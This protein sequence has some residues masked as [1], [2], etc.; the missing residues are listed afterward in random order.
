MHN[1]RHFRNSFSRT[2]LRA[3][4]TMLT[5]ATMVGWMVVWT[6]AA[7]AQTQ[8]NYKMI[9]PFTGGQDGANSYA[10]LTMDKTGKLYGTASAGGSQNCGG[11]CGLVFELTNN[12]SGWILNPMY[13]FQGGSD[14]STPDAR[15]V[16]GS[17]GSLYGTTTGYASGSGATVFKLSPPPTACKTA[18]CAWTQ[19]VLYD[20]NE[21]V[22]SL[23]GD[24]AFD[25]AGNIYGTTANTVYELT[26]LNGGW[27]EKILYNFTNGSDGGYPW[28]GVILDKTGSLYGT[29]FAG[30][31]YGYGTVFRLTLSES[32]WT[33]TVLYSFQNGS[34]GAEPAGGLIFDKSGNLY[35]TTSAWGLGKGGTVFKLTASN[36]NWLFSVI[37]SF[38]GAGPGP[39]GSLVM[40]EAGNLYGT[41][42]G[43]GA[44]GGGSVFKLTN[45]GD[46][47]QYT[48]LHSFNG[49]GGIN[50]F[51]NGTI[52][53]EGNFY[54]T[55]A[56]A[57]PYRTNGVVWEITP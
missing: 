18:Y 9:H 43:G 54:G 35:G 51:G 23:L 27:T 53:S 19:S 42:F 4:T 21:Y 1:Q 20:F 55:A 13:S 41:T 5:M 28:A 44:T 15:V 34:D 39:I 16:F 6:Q 30:G 37:H 7:P 32:G 25:Q 2:V 8:Q 31:V 57:G 14:G 40:D 49:D 11:G 3:A 50:P 26:P 24:L 33:E 10:G 38:A 48:L 47:W 46:D 36:G 22:G 29:T 45:S 52:D 12:G 17:D 56:Q